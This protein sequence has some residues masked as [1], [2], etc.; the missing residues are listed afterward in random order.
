MVELRAEEHFDCQAPDCCGVLLKRV[1]LD[2]AFEEA[3][4]L[5]LLV[6]DESGVVSAHL[7]D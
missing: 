6:L 1:C 2:A 3:E 7:L 5:V 4:E